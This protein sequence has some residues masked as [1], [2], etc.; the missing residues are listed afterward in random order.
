MKNYL[1]VVERIDV[2]QE[3]FNHFRGYN[4]QF[5]HQSTELR[6]I[7]DPVI[8][9][10]DTSELLSEAAKEFFMLPELEIQHALQENIKFEFVFRG[11]L[12]RSHLPHLISRQFFSHTRINRIICLL[13]LLLSPRTM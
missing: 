6:L 10:V 11:S 5:L 4:S 13:R 3:L 1:L 12:L 9:R 8:V 7:H 2:L